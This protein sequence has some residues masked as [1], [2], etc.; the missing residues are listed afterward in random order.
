MS[1]QGHNSIPLLAGFLAAMGATACCAGPLVLL[2]L[3]FGGAWVGSLTAL[4]P[5]RPVFIALAL[6]SLG[7]AG[8]RL[9]FGKAAQAACSTESGEPCALPRAWRNQRRIFWGVAVLSILLM[10]FPWYG[11]Y[12]LG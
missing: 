9:Y 1:E 7:W 3:G 4:A 11:I 8:Y 5:Y 6:G 12:F 2:M 10:A